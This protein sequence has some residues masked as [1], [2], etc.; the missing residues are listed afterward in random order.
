MRKE[1]VVPDMDTD[2]AAELAMA[3]ASATVTNALRAGARAPTF[4]LHDKLGNKV[5]LDQLL[6]SGPVVLNFLRGSWCSFGEE[7]LARFSAIHGRIALAGAKAVV[8]APPDASS[9]RRSDRLPVPEL[10]D[11]DLRVAR[12]FGVTFDLPEEL[13]RRYIDLGYAPPRRRQSAAFPV[14]VPATY[15]LDEDGIVVF[16]H[17]DFDYRNGMDGESLLKALDALQARREARDRNRGRLA[18]LKVVTKSL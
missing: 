12:A 1:L 14:P 2:A 3:R 10:V 15:L 18:V 17:V 5:M 11:T 13:R 4:A 6:R 8:L 16:A 7:N 9:H